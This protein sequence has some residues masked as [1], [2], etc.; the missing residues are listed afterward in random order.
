M[1]LNFGTE[2]ISVQIVAVFALS[3]KASGI[4]GRSI[5]AISLPPAPVGANTQVLLMEFQAQGMPKPL[6]SHLGLEVY[7]KGSHVAGFVG[8]RH[9]FIH[10]RQFLCP[11]VRAS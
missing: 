8:S 2:I 11:N 10:H 1:Q 9:S 3:S 5:A 4:Y 6:D 7:E